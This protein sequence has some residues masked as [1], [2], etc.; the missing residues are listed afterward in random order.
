MA[1]PCHIQLASS[2]ASTT[3]SPDQLLEAI[4][5]VG[6][7]RSSSRTLRTSRLGELLKSP[8]LDARVPV[9]APVSGRRAGGM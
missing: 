1:H 2:P 5:L 4:E 8:R 3:R 9:A 7:I 6:T